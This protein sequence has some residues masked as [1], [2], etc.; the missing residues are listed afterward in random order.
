MIE[1]Y[2]LAKEKDAYL[3]LSSTTTIRLPRVRCRN[4]LPVPKFTAPKQ[5][6]DLRV[7]ACCNTGSLISEGTHMRQREPCC[8]KWHSSKLHNSTSARR[9]SRC[10]FFTAATFT[11]SD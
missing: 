5:A 1:K 6:T 8:W 10:S 3:A 9:A 7:G 4:N 11:G 2:P